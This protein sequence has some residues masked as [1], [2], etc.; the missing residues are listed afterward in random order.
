MKN[1]R[2]KKTNEEL[3]LEALKYYTRGDFAKYSNAAYQ[4]AKRRGILDEICS[5]MINGKKLLIGIKS[6][7]YKWTDEALAIEALKYNNKTE[8]CK[9]SWGAYQTARSRGILD[10][11]CAHMPK[12]KKIPYENIPRIWI[13]EKIRIEALK[14]DDRADFKK[15]SPGAWSAAQEI[16]IL[17]EVCSHMPYGGNS[18]KPEKCIL[19]EI[20]NMYPNARKLIDRKVEVKDRIY[21]HGFEIDIYVPELDLG[22]EFDGGYHHSFKG[23]KRAHPKWPNEAIEIYHELKDA[24][25]ATKGIKILHIKEESWKNDKQA[26]IN[27]CLEFLR[28][29]ACA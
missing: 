28:L 4:M 9:G 7:A 19:F 27:Q 24:W 22:I 11:I 20:K 6:N 5:H 12:R 18:S 8:F 2:I 25:F 15:Y 17:A 29:K 3:T 23:L 21:I 16:G 14:Y 1:R 26:C 10:K 13:P